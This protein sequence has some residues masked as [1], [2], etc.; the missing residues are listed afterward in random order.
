[1]TGGLGS[2]LA[3]L[4]VGVPLG[5]TVVLRRDAV[6]VVAAAAAIVAALAL[7]PESWAGPALPTAHATA[8]T[9]EALLTIVVLAR[10]QILDTIHAHDDV[11]R[12]Q[13]RF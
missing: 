2:P 7:E 12:L 11:A 8:L 3:P 10:V 1:M 13:S 4:L 6:V 9:V 5:A